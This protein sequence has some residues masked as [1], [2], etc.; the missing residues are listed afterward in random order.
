MPAPPKNQNATKP[1][2]ERASAFW[3]LR[4]KPQDLA[5]WRRAAAPRPLAEVA[6]HLNRAFGPAGLP[7]IPQKV[8]EMIASP[9]ITRRANRI[10]ILFQPA[11]WIETNPDPALVVEWRDLPGQFYVLA[12]WGEDAPQIQEWT[13]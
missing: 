1:A 11:A 5:R 3:H 7:P 4:V 13:W 2:T 9:T 6:H 10:G 12:V 8:R